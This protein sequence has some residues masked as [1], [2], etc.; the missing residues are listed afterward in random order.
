MAEQGEPKQE[1][2]RDVE[3]ADGTAKA[4]PTAG[5]E[6]DDT[7]AV[8][9]HFVRSDLPERMKVKG[10]RFSTRKIGDD[11]PGLQ[12]LR[13]MTAYRTA[14]C[15]NRFLV[16]VDLSGRSYKYLYCYDRAGIR[17]LGVFEL[18]AGVADKERPR[19]K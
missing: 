2:A 6:A 16:D 5:R 7:L 18:A 13:E 3:R 12:W 17:L 9:E 14:A 4:L 10:L 19:P 11:T 8:T 1:P 15:A